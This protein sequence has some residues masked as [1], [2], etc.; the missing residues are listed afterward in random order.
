MT[1]A[2]DVMLFADVAEAVMLLQT[3]GGAEIE[4]SHSYALRITRA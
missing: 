4:E 1:L 3:I 2:A